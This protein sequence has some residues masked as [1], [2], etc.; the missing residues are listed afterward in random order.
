MR[1]ARSAG[2]ATARGCRRAIGRQAR[3]KRTPELTFAPDPRCARAPGW[4]RC[5]PRWPP[6]P[7][8]WWSIR[9]STTIPTQL[10]GPT[11][12]PAEPSWPPLGPGARPDQLRD[13]WPWSTRRRGGLAT[14]WSP[15]C[16]GSSH[17]RKVGHSG[18]LDP[19]ATGVLLVGVG[20]VT[21]LLRYLTVLAKAYEGEI[22]LGVETS[23]LD[24]AGEVVAT[25][26]MG[27]VT[28]PMHVAAAARPSPVTSCRSPRWCRR[29][30]SAGGAC[31]S[32]PE[33]ASRS[34]GRPGRS[35]ST[36]SRCTGGRRPRRVPRRGELLV[37]HLRPLPGRRPG[38]RARRRR[39]PARAAPHGDRLVHPGRGPSA[40][41]GSRSAATRRGPA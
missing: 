40:L 14:T 39:A 22:V 13:G 41:D 8:R 26:D 21:R 31:T 11:R 17:N 1:G 30:R 15:S 25:H 37:G 34:S 10:D 18:T 20:R 24:A 19:D 28:S 12:P 4:S 29:S 16:G 23:T 7:S 35:R 5:W 2:R 33:R 27:A 36:G 38:P 32:W 9:T 6:A 3:L